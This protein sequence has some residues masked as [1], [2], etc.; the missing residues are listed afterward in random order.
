M[1]ILT[2]YVW[3]WGELRLD[4][5]VGADWWESMEPATEPQRRGQFEM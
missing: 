2:H 3:V 1:R 4:R 5:E